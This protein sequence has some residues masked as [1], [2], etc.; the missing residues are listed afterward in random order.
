MTLYQVAEDQVTHAILARLIS[1]IFPN[2][3][4]ECISL[5]SRGGKILQDLNKYN[6]LA[7]SN[8]VVLLTD[9]DNHQCPIDLIGRITNKAENFFCRV[10][11]DEAESWLMA[12]SKSFAKYL[13]VPLSVIPKP[14]NK[15][16]R[17][18][19]QDIE[20]QF[21]YKPSMY[22]IREIANRSS[23]DTIKKGLASPDGFSKGPLYNSIIVPF[24]FEIWNP[25]EASCNSYSL[26]RTIERLK[27]LPT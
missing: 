13:G 16:P 23:K 24:I 5:P 9:L 1:E 14:L 15:R 18:N 8:P 21:P 19:D 17:R 6:I 26:R 12:D 27:S 2:N 3:D 22:L 11:V 7:Q 20:L 25:I 10:A 4:F